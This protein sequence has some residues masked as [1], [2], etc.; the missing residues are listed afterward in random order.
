MDRIQAAY[1]HIIKNAETI[2]LVNLSWGANKNIPKINQLHESM[3]GKSIHDVVA[4]GNT[5]DSGGS[6]ATS[7]DAFSAGAVD[8]NGDLTRFSSSDPKLDNPDV[9]ALGKNVKLARAPGTSMGHVIDEQ[10]VKASGTSF[11]AP[12]L[13]SAYALALHAIPTS[14][15]KDF[16]RNAKDIPGTTR[17]GQGLLRL[18]STLRKDDDPEKPHNPTVSG[19]VLE[20]GDRDVALIDADWLPNGDVNVTKKSETKNGV[21]I[22]VERE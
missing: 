21:T 2:D 19:N 13:G 20:I 6:P 10:F 14:W 12:W 4:A 3:V 16:E 1:K 9:S 22:H 8:E 5:G 11:A 17:D 7:K 18:A 15:D